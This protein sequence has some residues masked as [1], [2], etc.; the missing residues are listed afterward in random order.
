MPLE[1]GDFKFKKYL[2]DKTGGPL[3]NLAYKK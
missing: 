1:A 3:T 2:Q